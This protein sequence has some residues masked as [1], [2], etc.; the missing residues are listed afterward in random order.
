MNGEGEQGGRKRGREKERI[1]T[2]VV[3]PGTRFRNVVP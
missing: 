1:Y 3:T 2:L